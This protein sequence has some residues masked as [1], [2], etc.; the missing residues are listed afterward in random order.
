MGAIGGGGT[1]HPE[2]VLALHSSRAISL[3]PCP[4]QRSLVA[5]AV[6]G[7]SMKKGEKKNVSIHACQ[8]LKLLNYLIKYKL[9][10][11]Y[12][13]GYRIFITKNLDALRKKYHQE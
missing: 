12:A 13:W 9:H 7:L 6:I 1:E 4:A 3:T 10:I 5:E 8:V 2:F 11:W